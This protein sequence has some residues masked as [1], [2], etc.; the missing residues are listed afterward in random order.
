MVHLPQVHAAIWLV[1]LSSILAP[2][3]KLFPQKR[4]CLKIFVIFLKR[5]EPSLLCC[6][7]LCQIDR[8]WRPWHPGSEQ[9]SRWLCCWRLRELQESYS[10]ALESHLARTRERE[11]ASPPWLPTHTRLPLTWLYMLCWTE[12]LDNNTTRVSH[13]SW[14]SP[15]LSQSWGGHCSTNPLSTLVSWG[16]ICSFDYNHVIL[17]SATVQMDT[18]WY[19]KTLQQPSS[20]KPWKERLKTM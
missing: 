16:S 1:G 15:R 20:P 18:L 6:H 7:L 19:D 14:T 3:G 10:K 9:S 11:R 8:H 17:P 4:H 2:A 12:P 5:K 13:K